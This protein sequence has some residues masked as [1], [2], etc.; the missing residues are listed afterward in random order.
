MTLEEQEVHRILGEVDAEMAAIE[1]KLSFK[2]RLVLAIAMTAVT[3]GVLVGCFGV[4]VASFG[5]AGLPCALAA[6]GA[7]VVAYS[8]ITAW[9]STDKESKAMKAKLVRMEALA[10]QIEQE[11]ENQEEGAE[12]Q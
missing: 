9:L 5:G 11:A 7:L 4:T 10:A 8:Y 2:Q 12:G 6:V 3:T 1:D